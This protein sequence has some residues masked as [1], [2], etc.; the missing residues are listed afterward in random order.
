MTNHGTLHGKTLRFERRLAHSIDKVWHVLT[1]ED[2]T[3]YWFPGRIVGP[4]EPGAAVRFVFGPR[5]PGVVEDSLAALIASKQA[6]FDGAPP[7]VF[8][9]AIVAFEPPRLF[10]LLW[11]GDRA[12]FELTAD[13]D[14]TRLVLVYTF[15]EA[16]ARDIGAGWHVSL[17]WLANRLAGD[18]A[19]TSLA[20][21]EALEA[22]YRRRFA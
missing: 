18:T 2:E 9:G 3:A 1:D 19:P 4:R 7:A 11:A 5:P 14:A 6:A 16:D 10:E 20:G 17:D 21:F 12:R 8:E 13:G 22:D 15:V